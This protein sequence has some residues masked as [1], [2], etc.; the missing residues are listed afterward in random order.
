MRT[1]D[2]KRWVDRLELACNALDIL[3]SFQVQTF[4]G[5][6]GIIDFLDHFL[7]RHG[8][9]L[10]TLIYSFHRR[11]RNPVLQRGN[12][13]KQIPSRRRRLHPLHWRELYTELVPSLPAMRFAR[14]QEHLRQ[15]A[16]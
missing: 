7:L 9:D 1:L 10:L 15:R 3:A 14:Q 5:G 4:K 16:Y 11:T 6:Y 8:Y 13:H 12:D 2:N